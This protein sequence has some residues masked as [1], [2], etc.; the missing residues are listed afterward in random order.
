MPSSLQAQIT[1][2]AISPRLAIRIFLNIEGYGGTA[3]PG[4]A[5]S[6]LVRGLDG[7]QGL[8]ILHR[9]PAFDVDPDDLAVHFGLDLI[10]QFHGLDNTQHLPHAHFVTGLY[11]GLRIGRGT[12]VE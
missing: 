12:A 1:R 7:E 11:E 4:C 5:A 10:H 3:T 6:L 8:A 2:R 9:L